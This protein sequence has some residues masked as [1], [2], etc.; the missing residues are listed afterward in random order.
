MMFKTSEVG[1]SSRVDSPKGTSSVVVMVSS[2][3]TAT[4]E[5][6]ESHLGGLMA[7][8]LGKALRCCRRCE[9]YRCCRCCSEACCCHHY[10]CWIDPMKL[11][12]TVGKQCRY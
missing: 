1:V 3:G 4:S 12:E 8:L 11:K 5:N 6:S 2:V 9:A 10:F 7:A